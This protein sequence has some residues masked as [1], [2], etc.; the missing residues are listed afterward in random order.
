LNTVCSKVVEKTPSTF[1]QSII[2]QIYGEKLSISIYPHNVFWDV[3]DLVL[4]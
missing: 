2:P 3:I 1:I 4:L